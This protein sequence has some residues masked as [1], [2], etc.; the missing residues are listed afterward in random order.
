[1]STRVLLGL[2]L[3]ALISGG[4]AGLLLGGISLLFTVPVA[5]AAAIA[6]GLPSYFLLR[7]LGWLQPWQLSLAGACCASPALFFLPVHLYFVAVVLLSGVLSG[8]LFWAA[9]VRA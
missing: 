7:H 1:M 2:V 9:S 4:A 8:W 3:S 5:V 6:L